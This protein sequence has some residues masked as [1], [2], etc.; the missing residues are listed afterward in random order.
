MAGLRYPEPSREAAD[1]IRQDRWLVG[2]TSRQGEKIR[3]RR[4]RY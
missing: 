2:Q 4:Y 3:S 1:G